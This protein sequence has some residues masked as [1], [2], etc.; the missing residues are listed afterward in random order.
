MIE[1]QLRTKK[2]ARDDEVMRFNSIITQNESISTN[3]QGA[4]V[5]SSE[6]MK[7]AKDVQHKVGKET[8]DRIA[9][10]KVLRDPYLKQISFP[11]HEDQV[12]HVVSQ[13]S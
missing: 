1:E 5:T 12:T 4:A 13:I 10:L 9:E 7:L 2:Q 8:F 11:F 6:V 3:S